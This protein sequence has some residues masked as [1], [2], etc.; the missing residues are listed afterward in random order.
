MKGTDADIHNRQVI[1]AHN[2]SNTV[3]LWCVRNIYLTIRLTKIFFIYI[4]SLSIVPG[5]QLPKTSEFLEHKRNGSVFCYNIWSF[6]SSSW[7]QS[8]PLRWNG[9][10]FIHKPLSTTTGL[11]LMQWPKAFKDGAWGC[12][13]FPFHSLIS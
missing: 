9:Y 5:S 10:L 3:I 7:N 12:W 8:V 4:W 1:K 2:I 6:V 11:M 13:S